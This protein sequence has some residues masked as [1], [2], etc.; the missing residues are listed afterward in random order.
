MKRWLSGLLVLVMLF[1]AIPTIAEDA[2]ADES[3]Q[4]V[5][6][7]ETKEEAPAAKEEPTPEKKEEIHRLVMTERKL[8]AFDRPADRVSY[9]DGCKVYFPDGWVI[10]RFSGTEPR[11][12]IFAEAPSVKEADTLV[13]KMADFVNLP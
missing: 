3:P 2:P 12:R 1:T 8:P 10:I 6:T 13:R 7:V 9:L 5:E 4:V 11:I